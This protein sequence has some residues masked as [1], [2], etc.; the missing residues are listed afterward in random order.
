MLYNAAMVYVKCCVHNERAFSE[1]HKLKIKQ[2]IAGFAALACMSGMAHAQSAGSIYGTLGWFHFAPNDSS[3]PLKETSVGGSPVDISVPGT[4]AGIS[5]ADTVGFT[6]GYFATDHI[7]TELEM[8]VP[9]TFDLEGTGTLSQYGKLGSAKQWSPTLLL[10][11]FFN[12]PEAKFRPYVGIGVTH[13][14]FSDAKITNT[15][16]ESSVLHGPTDVDTDSSWAPVFNVGAV[17]NFNQHWFAGFSVSFIPLK[18]TATLNT[19]AQTPVG[20]LNVQSKAKITLNPIVT[21]LR[22]GYRF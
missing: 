13:V 5:S 20:T 9:P 3:G 21:Y 15:G 14:W 8:G 4:G 10:K 17:Y 12:A 19:A 7:A 18:A 22:V 16:F 11:Y 1:E 2:G 6:L